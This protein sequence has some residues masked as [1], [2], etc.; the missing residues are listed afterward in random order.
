MGLVDILAWPAVFVLGFVSGVFVGV[1]VQHR[2]L[3]REAVMQV[4]KVKTWWDAW[5]MSVVG[6][7]LLVIA[8]LMWQSQKDSGRALREVQRQSGCL[9]TYA[10]QLYESLAPRQKASEALQEAD[11]DFNDALV[12]LLTDSLSVSPDR[13]QVHKDAVALQKAAQHKQQVSAQLSEKRAQN[14]YPAPPK[15]VCPK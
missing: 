14:P 2:Q 7:L 15:E 3:A 6:A 5:G 9:T 4:R 12:A 8:L 10:N 1:K 13:D 11:E